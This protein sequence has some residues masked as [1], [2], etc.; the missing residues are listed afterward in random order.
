MSP[1]T[2]AKILTALLII[3]SLF[4]YLEWGQNN[5][6]LLFQAE[7]EIITKL[8]TDPL[9]ALHPF[10]VLPLLGQVF[11]LITLF[12]KK[13]SKILTYIGIGGIGIL[14]ALMFLIGCIELNY[15][16]LLSTVPFLLLAFINIRHHRKT[17]PAIL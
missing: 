8:F 9:S 17:K 14:L 10:T 12:Q 7:A 15:K 1:A 6:I 16:I 2:K 13:Q 3:S 4:G 11:L 5:H